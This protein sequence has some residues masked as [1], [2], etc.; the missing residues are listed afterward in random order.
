MTQD[1]NSSIFIVFAG[2]WEVD[3]DDDGKVAGLF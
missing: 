2:F 1:L 3:I